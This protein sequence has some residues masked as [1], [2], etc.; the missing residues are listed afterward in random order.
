MKIT[1]L[2]LASLISIFLLNS[3]SEDE[4][5][6]PPINVPLGSYESGVLVLNEGS[7]GTNS[8]VSYISLD[9]NKS[10]NNIFSLVNPS[11]ILGQT[12]QSIGFNGELA[13][14][15]VNQ[16]DKIEIVNRYTMAK[17][18]SITTGLKNPRYITFANGKGYVT[19]W[20]TTTFAGPE[21]NPDDFVAVI[22]LSNN[23]VSSTIPVVEGPERII[24]NGN[25]LY[26]CHKGG[27]SYGSTISVI[28]ST[29]NT[30]SSTINVGDVPSA[31]QI[32]DG[33]LWVLCEGNPS[34]APIET[35]GKLHK[36]AL[37]T[38]TITTTFSFPNDPASP[39]VY[40]HP[41][42]LDVYNNTLYYTIKS[43]IYKMP[44]SPVAPATSISLPLNPVF[45]SSI[46]NIYGFALKNNYIYISGYGNAPGDYANP[47]KVNVHSLGVAA[48][49]PALGILVKTFTVGVGPNGFYFNQ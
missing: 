17:V 49:S 9:L 44:L 33:F 38:N 11:T 28:N 10:Q 42:N 48:Q 34:Y 45:S 27:Y 43:G 1:K 22:N 6:Q 26:V 31:M 16:A 2:L 30:V 36:I 39:L 12:A 3:C 46:D 8:S 32:N 13:Y 19:N 5:N 4:L 14:I 40:T 21:A 23:T 18:G 20:G 25:N 37:G 7:N 29:N 24:L 15:V 47:G 41:S 35:G